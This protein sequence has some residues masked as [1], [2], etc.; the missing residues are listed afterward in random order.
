MERKCWGWL[1]HSIRASVP[2]FLTPIPFHSLRTRTQLPL[3]ARVIQHCSTA[4][5]RTSSTSPHSIESRRDYRASLPTLSLVFFSIWVRF[6]STA[7][8][9]TQTLTFDLKVVELLLA[10]GAIGPRQTRIVPPGRARTRARDGAFS[11]PCSRV[12][13]QYAWEWSGELI[14][15][16]FLVYAVRSPLKDTVRRQSPRRHGVFIYNQRN[17]IHYVESDSKGAN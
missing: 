11:S 15:Q 12:D 9:S 1:P 3:S 5:A 6:Y 10:S 7:A 2:R 13:R 8:T 4:A 16:P 17:Q 14:L